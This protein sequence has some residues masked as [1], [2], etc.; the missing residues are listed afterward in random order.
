MAAKPAAG[1]IAGAGAVAFKRLLLAL[2]LVTAG[3]VT[4]FYLLNRQNQQSMESRF[5]QLAVAEATTL[6]R[7][8]AVAGTRLL[9]KGEETL[10]SFLER[11]M[12]D[13]PV[14]YVA[15][16]DAGGLRFADTKFEGYLPL[17]GRT[18]G[19]RIVATHAGPILEVST[20]LASPPGRAFRVTLGFFL[21]ALPEIQQRSRRNFLILTLVQVLAALLALVGFVSF[22]R[23]LARKEMQV[24]AERAE[25]ERLREASLV[26][27]AI[28][29]EIKNPLHSLSLSV[30][31]LEENCRNADGESRRHLAVLR[32]ETRR[33][34]AILDQVSAL[35]RLPQPAPRLLRG[36][37][38]LAG[39][40]SLL[41]PL[42]RDAT[43]D[44][45]APAGIAFT[46][47]PDLLTQ[48]LIN[49][50]KNSGEAGARHIEVTAGLAGESVMLCV[51]DDGSGIPPPVRPRLFEPQMSAK[52]NGAGMGLAI[53][54]RIVWFLGGRIE[55]LDRP[56]GGS[57]FRI[58]LPREVA[59]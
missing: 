13:D 51:C 50:V 41:Q 39:L 56:G 15:L 35:G 3:M 47:D 55:A 52:P 17:S 54:R 5:R 59:P 2:A 30:Q 20:S 32:Q 9:Q 57:E 7:I 19:V 12:E 25:K 49:L 58:T 4:L 48:V 6:D 28:N 16:R 43:L 42:A 22:Q 24:Q 36:D 27:A 45:A 53:V 23:R 21:E 1:G 31:V 33:L 46:S 38:F 37:E 11:M 34:K 18:D 10:V 14:V 40:R 44:L 8:M 26:S 29:H